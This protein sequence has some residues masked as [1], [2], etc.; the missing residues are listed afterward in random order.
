VIALTEAK[1]RL[2]LA[3]T[4]VELLEFEDKEYVVDTIMESS[5]GCTEAREKLKG[6]QDGIKRSAA[7]PGGM[8]KDL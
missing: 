2:L 6:I 1:E 5:T 4:R 8:G 3:L 7:N